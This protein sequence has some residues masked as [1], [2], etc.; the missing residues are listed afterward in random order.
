MSPT[1]FSRLLIALA[2]LESL[3]ASE[4]FIISL[5]DVTISLEKVF[6]SSLTTSLALFTTDAALDTAASIDL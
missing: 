2:K 6:G 4:V 3:V 1:L 5:I